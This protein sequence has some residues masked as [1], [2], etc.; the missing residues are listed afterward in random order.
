MRKLSVLFILVFIIISA[1]KKK[2]DNGTDIN[3]SL[4][5]LVSQKWQSFQKDKP[6]NPS[7]VGIYY[8][9]NGSAYS[10][11]YNLPGN[12]FSQLRFRA[13]S[14]TKTFT[15]AAVLF[16]QQ[17]GK[18]RISDTITNIIPGKMI[19]YVPHDTAY[20]IPYKGQITL[21]LLLNHRAGVFDV[22]NNPIP[23]TIQ[24]PYKGRNYIEYTLET[25]GRDHTFTIDEL[26]GV[27]ALNHLTFFVPGAAFHYSNTGYA[28]LG[29]IIE[30]TSGVPYQDFIRNTFFTPL[31][32]GESQMVYFGPDTLVPDPTVKSYLRYNGVVYEIIGSN[33]SANVA[34]GS[35]V[36]TPR[37]LAKWAQLL[38]SGHAGL[39]KEWVDSMT[40][41][42]PTGEE[43]VFYGLG[44]EG[45]PPDLGY[46]HN[47]AHEAFLTVMRYL[48]SGAVIVIVT[49]YLESNLSDISAES[50]VLYDIA[51]QALKI[52]GDL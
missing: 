12:N 29:K 24:Q 10:A 6:Q 38:Y 48:P 5:D 8:L 37:D 47:G 3:Q 22:T 42:V 7:G 41:M 44:C 39:N 20:E 21:R 35:L 50:E 49:N 19:P 45:N 25:A 36:T 4:S 16:L 43:H 46:G 51:R 17:E 32:M 40:T 1:C 26:V 14:T 52:T 30:R 9:K 2:S 28:M 15:A 11:S 23:D 27:D 31:K 18:L 13:A 34:E 33:L